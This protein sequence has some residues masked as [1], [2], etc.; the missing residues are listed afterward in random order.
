MIIVYHKKTGIKDLNIVKPVIQV[1]TVSMFKLDGF[2][3]DL[4]I[5][6]Y[7]DGLV[8]SWTIYRSMIVRIFVFHIIII[9]KLEIWFTIV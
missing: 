5:H 8:F 9:V 2:R 1:R 3:Y 6:S 7:F 4:T